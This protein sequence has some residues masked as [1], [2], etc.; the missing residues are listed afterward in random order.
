MSVCVC[1]CMCVC[2]SVY[3]CVHVGVYVLRSRRV[4]VPLRCGIQ[5]FTRTHSCTHTHTPECTHAPESCKIRRTTDTGRRPQKSA[6]CC[7]LYKV[8]RLSP[9]SV[10]RTCGVSRMSVF[11]CTYVNVC[12]HVC[13]FVCGGSVRVYACTGV[14][15]VCVCICVCV[16]AHVGV[17]CVYVC[18]CV[19]AHV[20]VACV[21]VYVY[22]CMCVYE[23]EDLSIALQNKNGCKDE[24]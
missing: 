19:W 2:V 5:T 15:C 20:G 10:A 6:I 8:G 4:Q 17:A 18:M 23:G 13:V 7:G 24:T 9:P 14:A 12:M 1:V 22:V 11:V 21:Y 3:V 16:W